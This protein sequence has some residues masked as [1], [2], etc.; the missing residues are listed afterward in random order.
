MIYFL[1]QKRLFVIV[2]GVCIVFTSVLIPLAVFVGFLSAISIFFGSIFILFVPGFLST[3]IFF[4][5]HD[6]VGTE[7]RK[8]TTNGINSIERCT[9]SILLSIIISS[10]VVYFLGKADA[11]FLERDIMAPGY[12]FTALVMIS[13][14]FSFFALI[15]SY[16]ERN[17]REK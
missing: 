10:A 16:F 5:F 13:I 14:L 7:G 3:F 15:R 11:I 4:P 12:F 6:A 1:Q 17:R 2:A 8:N 9:Y